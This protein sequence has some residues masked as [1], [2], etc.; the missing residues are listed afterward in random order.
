LKRTLGPLLLVLP[1]LLLGLVAG[2]LTAP[3]PP[4]AEAQTPP[5][6]WSQTFDGNPPAPVVVN[7]RANDLMVNA[8]STVMDPITTVDAYVGHGADCAGPP[9]THQLSGSPVNGIFYCRDHLMTSGSESM[10][11][12][13]IPNA[14]GSLANGGEAVL[15]FDVSTLGSSTRDWIEVW[16]V[17]FEDD[18]PIVGD[19]E[20]RPLRGV[21][22][23]SHL[24]NSLTD[25]PGWFQLET[26][27]DGEFTA[28]KPPCCG[29]QL[30]ITP[31]ASVR[32]TFEFRVSQS[33]ISFKTVGSPDGNNAWGD[34]AVPAGIIDWDKTLFYIH[35]AAYSPSKGGECPPTRTDCGHNTWHWDNIQLSPAQPLTVRYA[36]QRLADANNPEFIFDGPAPAN[37]S[38]RGWGKGGQWRG[39]QHSF[40][41]GVT[42]QSTPLYRDDNRDGEDVSLRFAVPEGATRVR[43][44]RPGE[45][46]LMVGDPN[47]VSLAAG[48]PPPTATAAPATATAAPATATAVPPT[49]TLP[50]PTAT[51]VPPTATT[52]PPT[53]T[54]APPTATSAPATPTAAP[55]QTIFG[56]GSPSASEWNQGQP[57][58]MA[59]RFRS[60]AAGTVTG[61]RFYKTANNTGAHV[62]HLWSAGGALLAT[63]TFSGESGS[64]WQ[65]ATLSSPVAIAANTTYV[66]SYYSPTGYLAFQTGGLASAV[67]NG[68]LT[69]LADGTDGANGGFREG[70]SGFPNNTYASTNYFVDVVFAP[71][72]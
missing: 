57:L 55:A 5:T 67:T 40:D 62:G 14:V 42:W 6:A 44:R 29:D 39:L 13:L 54:S 46:N 59:T 34:T 63:A 16:A 10:R 37:A 51:A 23:F 27:R 60:D 45:P 32:S 68:H 52:A 2:I 25:G 49:A 71:Q 9:A 43:F 33:H 72:P 38:F 1:V 65:T 3:L 58:E 64:G 53:A 35:H 61:I 48:S 70:A 21:K 50:P 30:N 19:F 31:S 11:L 7:P 22:V 26:V 69:A 56:A 4:A 36:Q 18:Y 28:W 47:I 66:V 15:R 20:K 41:N 17:P 8:Y 24:P 12:A